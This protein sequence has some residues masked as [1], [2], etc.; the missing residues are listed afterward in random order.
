MIT[1]TVVALAVFCTYS[2]PA[3]YHL[4][5]HQPGRDLHPTSF[6]PSYAFFLGGYFAFL[7]FLGV[8]L[9]FFLGWVALS[10]FAQWK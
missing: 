10:L 3:Y 6:A 4:L 1:A 7:S 2:I 9:M 5:A 8:S